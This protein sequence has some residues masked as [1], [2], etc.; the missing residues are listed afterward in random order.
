MRN[1]YKRVERGGLILYRVR[2]VEV[3]SRGDEEFWTESKALHARRLG[4]SFPSQPERCLACESGALLD[5][6]DESGK[7]GKRDRRLFYLEGMADPRFY[8]I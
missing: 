2:E 1:L 3:E 8:P 5:A 4:T 6:I 7:P